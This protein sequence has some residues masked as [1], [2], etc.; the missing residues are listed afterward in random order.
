MLHNILRKNIVASFSTTITNVK[1]IWIPVL[2]EILFFISLG[3][4]VLPFRDGVYNNL[5]QLG[6]S[7]VQA[8][9][10]LA[11]GSLTE[12]I[13]SQSALNILI[14]GFFTVLLTYILYSLFQG[15]IWKFS[16]DLDKKKTD[17]LPYIKRFFLINLFWLLLFIVYQ[18]IDFILLYI[19][20]LNQNH[21]SV[22]RLSMI[23]QLL[24]LIIIYF[25]FIS[26][27]RIR[28]ETVKRSIGESFKIGIHKFPLF[29]ITYIFIAALFG[30]SNL[31]LSALSTINNTI[32]I[33]T[34]I[35]IVLPLMVF[36]RN[37]I[38]ITVDPR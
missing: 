32:M 10:S 3:F 28:K 6:D 4:F 13:F 1:K 24:I 21:N 15:F 17:Y 9:D 8:S 33:I 36:T 18:I 11:D 31:L 38:K 22:F 19:D 20:I 5:V 37:L 27:V 16:F 14:L 30:L 2:S 26:Y 35:I 34:G 12:A 23:S 7:I 29:V 25:A